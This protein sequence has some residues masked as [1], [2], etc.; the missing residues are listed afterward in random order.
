MIPKIIIFGYTD[1]TVVNKKRIATCKTC[2]K[3]ITDGGATTSNFV[4]HLKLHKE[5]FEQYQMNKSVTSEPQQS[6]IS[7]FMETRV[8]QYSMNHTQQKAIN[9]AILSD[10]VID[11]NLPLS[12]VENKSF[13]H[14]LSVVD[15][16]YSPVCC[17]TLTSK[18]ENL[19]TER[20]SKLK[21]QLS[22]TDHVSVTVDI[23]SDRKMRGFLGVTVHCMEKDGERLQLK[24]NLLACDSVKGPHMA[25]RICEQFEAI[26]GEYGIKDKLDYIISDNAAN[27][28]KAFTVC[29]LIEQEDEVH[30]E[31]HLDDPELWNDL[32]LE[33]QQTVDATITKKQRLQCFAHTL[34]LVVGDGLKETKVMTPCLSKLLK[35]S[36]L[37]HTNT[38]FKEVF[39]AEFGERGIPAAVNTRWNSTLRQVKAVVQC[40]HRKLSHVLEKAGHKELLFTVREWNKLKELVDILKPFGEAT[41]MT[42][43]EKIV[44]IS[45]VVPSVL[46]LNHHLEQR[47]PHVHFLSGLVRSLQASL[48]KRFLGIFINVKMARTQDGITAPFSDPVYLKAAAL[49]PA[50]SLMWV[51]HHV[52]VKEE[53]KEEVAQRVKELILEDATWTEQAVPLVD[54]KEREDYSLGQEDGLFAAYCKRQKKAVGTSP[55][56]QLSHYLDICEGQNALLFWAMNRKALPSLCRVA[57]RVLAVPASSALV[58]RVF[59]HGGIIP[60]PHRAQMT[61]RLLA[62]LLFCKCNAS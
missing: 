14:F 17:R 38:T 44:T 23:W 52:L 6:P 26:C 15:S 21:T 8:G 39:E 19:A 4:R 22:N 11:C 59:S 32:T 61:D 35:I 28:R 25:E 55:A 45:S 43:G 9:N 16:K 36:S 58:E 31:D 51:E 53:V 46:S 47:K 27:M 7:Q 13:R 57:V 50:F 20:R 40:D 18:V 5:R 24:S 12:V 49:D 30:D 3:K 2:G 41:D 33:D 42:Q 29:F 37:L 60:R 34:Q 1:Y 62:N 54:E 10:L 56:L 48:N